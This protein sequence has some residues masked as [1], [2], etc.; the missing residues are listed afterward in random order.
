MAKK[1]LRKQKMILRK[2]SSFKFFWLIPSFFCGYLVAS[3]LDLSHFAQWAYQGI[4]MKSAL[5][6]NIKIA[7]KPPELPK[8][9]FEFYTMLAKSEKPTLLNPPQLRVPPPGPPSSHENQI[10]SQV[11]SLSKEIEKASIAKETE[12]ALIADKKISNSLPRDNDRYWLQVA[13]F[14]VKNDAERMKAALILKG[15]DVTITNTSFSQGG[16]FRVLIGPY[17]TKGEAEKIQLAVANQEHI[18]GMVRKWDA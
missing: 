4:F 1:R 8:P 15:F 12:K 2:S 18:K 5:N 10:K 6:P 7:E 13:S 9:K 14:K 16:W 3:F 11:A 17:Q